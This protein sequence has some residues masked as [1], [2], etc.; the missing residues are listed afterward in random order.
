VKLVR[1]LTENRAE[2]ADLVMLL[3]NRGFA[4]QTSDKSDLFSPSVD[5]EIDLR[6]VP[7]RV[8]LDMA[9][10]MVPDE[11]DVFVFSD[12]LRESTLAQEVSLAPLDAAD[13][14]PSATP[15]NALTAESQTSSHPEHRHLVDAMRPHEMVDRIGNQAESNVG[16]GLEMLAVQLRNAFA[17]TQAWLVRTRRL[18]IFAR[19]R[20]ERAGFLRVF[21]SRFASMFSGRLDNRAIA[22][23]TTTML[24]IV[25]ILENKQPVASPARG[26]SQIASPLQAKRDPS[27]VPESK[28]T[29][30]YPVASAIPRRRLVPRRRTAPSHEDKIVIHHRE[31][32]VSQPVFAETQSGI[33]HFSDMH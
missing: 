18:R 19:V 20:F 7:L 29:P 3:E 11:V 27:T 8:A 14:S 21:R 23:A 17:R 26:H 12:V 9:H 32:V 5:L 30:G 25:I 16:A 28:S 33:K 10:R 6:A 24:L 2:A 31:G 1:V 22:I 13:F 4:V 15:L